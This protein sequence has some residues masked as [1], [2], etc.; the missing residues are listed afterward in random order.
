MRPGVTFESYIGEIGIAGQVSILFFAVILAYSVL[1]QI[2]RLDLS[3]RLSLIPLSL[4][5][6]TLGIF[7]ISAETIHAIYS[8]GS[9]GVAPSV[10][11]YLSYFSEIVQVL[12]LT[13]MESV[14]L[15]LTSSLLIM[16][17]PHAEQVV[18]GKPP[19]APQPPR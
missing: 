10:Y 13:A 11:D 7:G 5:P 12:P 19:E 14:I 17:T 2:R 1:I 6:V 4:I 16:N 8:L 15:L 3:T 9:G 18:D